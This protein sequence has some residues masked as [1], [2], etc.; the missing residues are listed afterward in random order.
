MENDLNFDLLSSQ[1]KRCGSSFGA[2]QTHG[3]LAG[4]LAVA[5]ASVGFEWLAQVLDGTDPQNA[6]RDECEKLLHR[7]FE[8]TYRQLSQRQSDFVLM[9]PDDEDPTAVRAAA[10]GSWCEGFL[11]G[12]VSVRDDEALKRRLGEEPISDIIKDLL[13]ITRAG[14][15]EEN[16]SEDDDAAYTELVEYLRV[17]AQLVFEELAE[18]RP[19]SP[20]ETD[21]QTQETLH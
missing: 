7:V 19:R 13:Q 20:A 6:A 10:L 11:H 14:A 17:A 18:Y 3:L 5:G 21:P 4:K 9:M 15:D 16:Q 12:L 2:A 8:V 1:L